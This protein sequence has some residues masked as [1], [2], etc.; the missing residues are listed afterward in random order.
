MWHLGPFA[1]TRVCLCFVFLILSLRASAQVQNGEITG[2]VAD[3][4]GAVVPD[5]KIVLQNLGTR[6]EIQVQTNSEGI[7]TAKELNVGAYTVRVE[8]RGFKTAEASNLVL[9]AGTVLRV[10]FKLLLG[11]RT[12]IVEVT[13]AVAPVNTETSRLSQEAT[14]TSPAAASPPLTVVVN[15]NAG[16]KK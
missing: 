3:P 4:S 12:E 7:Y 6:Y 13:D 2:T 1:T 10:D 11:E 16:A 5:A 9:N 15:W 8:A 14:N